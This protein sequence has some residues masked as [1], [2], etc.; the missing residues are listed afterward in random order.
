MLQE[1]VEHEAVGTVLRR[2]L[3][4]IGHVESRDNMNESEIEELLVEL[5]RKKED[6][7]RLTEEQR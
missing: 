6:E 5:Y 2:L 3:K 1:T 7:S 4:K